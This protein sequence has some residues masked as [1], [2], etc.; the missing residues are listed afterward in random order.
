METDN[1]K[2]T[3]E[4]LAKEIRIGL[5]EKYLR[6]KD[7]AEEMD[8]SRQWISALMN[9]NQLKG[10]QEEALEVIKKMKPKN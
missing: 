6:A 10:R 2:K 5:A 1:R 9:P 4:D 8:K 3:V 7:L